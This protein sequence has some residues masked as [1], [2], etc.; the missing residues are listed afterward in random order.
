MVSVTAIVPTFN[1]AC[2]VGTALDSILRQT[3]RPLEIIVIDDGSTDFTPSVLAGYGD[4]I[5][6]VR[7]ENG[8]KSDA[9]NLALSLSKGDGIWIFDDDDVAHPAAL[10]H[11]AGALARNPGYGFAYG[12]YAR[13][14]QQGN[15]VS[16]CQ[17]ED[18]SDCRE[19]PLPIGLMY[20]CFIHQPGLLVRRSCY[21]AIGPFRS[22]LI[23]SQDYDMILRLSRRFA[24]QFVDAITFYQRQH[25]GPRGSAAHPIAYRD[26]WMEWRRF[27]RRIFEALHGQYAL[28]DFAV[29]P[30]ATSTSPD[31]WRFAALLQRFCIFAR[32]GLWFLASADLTEA[33]EIA[34]TR[35]VTQLDPRLAR[36]L[37]RG[38]ELSEQGEELDGAMT[39]LRPVLD[40]FAPARL[41]REIRQGLARPVPYLVRR[42][43]A[44]HGVAGGLASWRAYAALLGH[45][46]VL[47][48]FAGRLA[49]EVA[50][51]PTTSRQGPGE[52]RSAVPRELLLALQGSPVPP[53]WRNA[54]VPPAGKPDLTSHPHG[55]LGASPP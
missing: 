49:T 26:L 1:R 48:A 39:F 35:G 9:I 16:C 11:M 3:Y 28:S 12:R 31:D 53:P 27:D 54:Q 6:H 23:R 37:R 21:E 52:S 13:F 2:L 7:K 30:Q 4:R 40:R 41:R 29:Q 22:D 15:Q 36:I 47:R 18:F 17:P 43:A 45:R 50:R 33:A 32:K 19:H 46:A 51:Q 10:E 42:E 8:G 25:E 5:R 34:A 24:G 38:L 14:R 55:A 20:R 44:W